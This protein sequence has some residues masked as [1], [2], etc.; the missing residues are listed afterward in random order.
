MK[1][2]NYISE[3]SSKSNERLWILMFMFGVLKM[4]QKQQS[5]TI[6]NVVCMTFFRF[7]Q[8]RKLRYAYYGFPPFAGHESQTHV[9]FIFSPFNENRLRYRHEMSQLCENI[10]KSI[11]HFWKMVSIY[12]KYSPKWGSMG[13]K[14]VNGSLKT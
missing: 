9:R 13:Q 3:M 1:S 6:Y 10:G 14:W 2:E 11:Y 4:E 7:K 8:I 5:M 12:Q